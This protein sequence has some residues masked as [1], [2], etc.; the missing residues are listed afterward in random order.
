MTRRAYVNFD[1][2]GPDRNLSTRFTVLQAGGVIEIGSANTILQAL[3]YVVVFEFGFYRISN[4]NQTLHQSKWLR[5]MS[6][7]PVRIDICQ[8]DLSF[9]KAQVSVALVDSTNTKR[10][11]LLTQQVCITCR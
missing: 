8:R 9:Y 10:Q 1:E 5:R 7:E 4:T 11:A 2:S 6:M 3:F